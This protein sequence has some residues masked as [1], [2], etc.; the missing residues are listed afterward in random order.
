MLSFLPLGSHWPKALQGFDSLVFFHENLAIESLLLFRTVYKWF[1]LVFYI[2]YGIGAVSLTILVL[3][4]L[5]ILAFIA[6]TITV[7]QGSMIVFYYALYF[8]VLGRDF[9]DMCADRMASTL[10]V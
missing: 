3:D 6:D 10:G 5:G 4:L 2:C 8:G 7:F 1:Y 9:A